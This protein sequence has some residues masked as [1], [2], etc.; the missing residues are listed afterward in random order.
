MGVIEVKKV[1]EDKGY[2][3]GIKNA[4]KFESDYQVN[5][6]A[7]EKRAFEYNLKQ[8]GMKPFFESPGVLQIGQKTSVFDKDSQIYELCH[9]MI[10]GGLGQSYE[11]E[12]IW[13]YLNHDQEPT[14]EHISHIRHVVRNLNRKLRIDF[15]VDEDFFNFKGKQVVFRPEILAKVKDAI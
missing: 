8:S 12:D 5:K 10:S 14:K 4:E 7:N 6:K 1:L 13:N 15:K 3:I 11:A 9:Y 2:I